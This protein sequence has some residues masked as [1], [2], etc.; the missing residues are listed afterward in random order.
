MSL[1]PE[2]R[3]A[4]SV[5]VKGWLPEQLPFLALEESRLDLQLLQKENRGIGPSQTK[6]MSVLAEG[7]VL[8]RIERVRFVTG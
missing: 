1:H 8:E 7:G 6:L 4:H 5:Q 3:T 2:P